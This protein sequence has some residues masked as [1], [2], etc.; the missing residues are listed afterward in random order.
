MH[1][2]HTDHAGS[3]ASNQS[4]VIGEDILAVVCSLEIPSHSIPC[5]PMLM[6]PEIALWMYMFQDHCG[7]LSTSLIY[8]VVDYLLS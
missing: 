4:S 2:S 8:S 6:E 1:K 3:F 5:I 7:G